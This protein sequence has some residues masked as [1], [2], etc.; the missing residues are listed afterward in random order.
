MHAT[1]WKDRIDILGS[2]SLPK[3]KWEPLLDELKAEHVPS[4]T[5]VG[6]RMAICVTS[7][8][9][10]CFIYRTTDMSDEEIIRILRNY[11]IP[12]SIGSEKAPSA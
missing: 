4:F 7:G 9:T 8:R 6:K 3:E 5:P 1:I 10:D 2:E 11:G 12:A